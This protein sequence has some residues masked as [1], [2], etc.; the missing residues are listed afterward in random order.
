MAHAAFDADRRKAFEPLHV[1]L[2]QECRDHDVHLYVRNDLEAKGS[3]GPWLACMQRAL[4]DQQPYPPFTHVCFLPDDAIL[5][6]EWLSVLLKI[7]EANPERLYDL[8]TNH[9]DAKLLTMS[10]RELA[11]WVNAKIMSRVKDMTAA[12]VHDHVIQRAFSGMSERYTK[13]LKDLQN[14]ETTGRSWSFYSTL[15]SCS[16]LG[17]TMPVS[18]MREHLAWRDANKKD[19]AKLANDEGVAL[20]AMVTSRRIYK[21]VPPLASHDEDAHSLDS[22]DH[23]KGQVI[24]TSTDFNPEHDY[25]SFDPAGDAFPFGRSYARNHWDVFFKTK[26][27]DPASF[28]GNCLTPSSQVEREQL[29][30][31]VYAIERNGQVIPNDARRRV[32]IATPS[33]TPPLAQ[34]IRSRDAVISDLREHGLF[35]AAPLAPG[36]SAITLARN[37]L[38]QEFLTTPATHLFWWDND[39]EFGDPSFLRQM[40]ATERHVLGVMYPYRDLSQRVVGNPIETTETGWPVAKID[41]DETMLVGEIGTGALLIRREVIVAIIAAG[42]AP[43]YAQNGSPEINGHPAW[44]VFENSLEPEPRA[45]WTKRYV[46]EDYHFC[47]LARQVG[48]EIR[49][50][51]PPVARH[52]GVSPSDGHVLEAW[53]LKAPGSRKD[54]E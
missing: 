33:Y 6:K 44:A 43:L 28:P 45:P 17:G 27:F 2:L 52:W 34:F 9:G 41:P 48:Y 19:V 25:A 47:K 22:N 51:V 15:D 5:H 42:L 21:P 31:R 54:H 37:H 30:E 38:L 50:F 39:L 11:P 46:T 24:R 23:Q 40:M 26:V 8:I 20:W 53:S 14:Q 29:V 49:A 18:W 36:L 1:R 16:L 12:K 35:Y 3:Y 10:P 32:F 4:T 7:I 13:I